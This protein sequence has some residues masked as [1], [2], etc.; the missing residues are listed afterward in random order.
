M[1]LPQ[2]DDSNVTRTAD[3]L[4]RYLQ[5]LQ[6]DDLMRYLQLLQIDDV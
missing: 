4:M 6:I 2:I 3:D 5:L 1:Q